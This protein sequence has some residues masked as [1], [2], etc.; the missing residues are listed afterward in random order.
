MV[1]ATDTTQIKVWI[2][3]SIKKLTVDQKN[4]ITNKAGEF[5]GQWAAH[6]KKLAA[7]FE[8]L[9]D[10]YLVFY[11]DQ[12]WE[13]NSGCSI[14]ASVAFI[15]EIEAK[16]Q[17]GLLDRLQIGFLKEEE[18]IFYHFSDLNQLYKDGVIKDKDLVF[19]PLVQDKSEFEDSFLT[20]FSSSPYSL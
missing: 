15:R 4:D 8:I 6:G 10:H 20:S 14:D 18:V 11:V 5:V 16:Y 13:K 19:N 9:Y 1:I 7:D 3:R 12:S 2:Y 17:L